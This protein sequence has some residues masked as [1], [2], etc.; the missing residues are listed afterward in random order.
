MPFADQQRFLKV[1]KSNSLQSLLEFQPLPI[2]HH[3]YVA[4]LTGLGFELNHPDGVP[5]MASFLPEPLLPLPPASCQHVV[6]AVVFWLLIQIPS[7]AQ[8]YVLI[9][10]M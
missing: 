1:L 7:Y 8:P 2:C 9:H 4:A 10:F 6:G 3:P 5:M